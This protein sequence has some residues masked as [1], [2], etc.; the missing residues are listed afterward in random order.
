MKKIFNFII[1]VLLGA[2]FGWVLIESQAISWYRIQEM[3]YFQSFHMYGL[4]GSAIATGV[5]SLLIIKKLKIKS[6]YKNPIVVKDKPFTWKA[7]LTGG[8]IFGLGW[9]LTGACSAPLLILSGLA[10]PI[11]LLLLAG[12]L[13]GTF[14]YGV[15]KNKLPH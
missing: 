9:G 11:G 15:L 7:N 4:L 10:W 12:A 6:I 8:I 14:L 13:V 1:S 3:F 2:G 5:I